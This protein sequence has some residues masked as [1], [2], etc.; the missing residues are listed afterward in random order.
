[1]AVAWRS[2]SLILLLV[3][4]FQL[5]AIVQ[6]QPDYSFGRWLEA[7]GRLEAGG[8]RK[9][10][11]E[12]ATRGISVEAVLAEKRRG[13]CPLAAIIFGTFPEQLEKYE[14]DK[15]EA[16]ERGISFDAVFAERARAQELAQAEREKAKRAEAVKR[17][18]IQLAVAATI[19]IAVIVI[20]FKARRR[21]SR[22]WRRKSKAFR[23]WAFGSFF[24][25]VAALLYIWLADPD[26]L[27]RTGYSGKIIAGDK[28]LGLMI[29]PP[30]FL[31]AVWFGYKRFVDLQVKAE[32]QRV[33]S[34][35]DDTEDRED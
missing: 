4:S 16:A 27:Y 19:A 33:I 25:A 11:A 1:M 10:E 17:Q 3:A 35:E 6:A 30:L 2:I 28:L 22:R 20:V 13:M 32:P 21:I 26:W 31:G 12:A 5:A 34:D 15:A 18:A 24:W 7:S 14:K 9:V 23:V 8:G 29:V